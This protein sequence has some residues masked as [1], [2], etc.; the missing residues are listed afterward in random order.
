MKRTLILSV[1][2][3][4]VLGAA[5][6]ALAQSPS[7]GA[8]PSSTLR[9]GITYDLYTSNPLRACGCG[10]EY[11]WMALQYDML[12]NFDKNTLEPA[13]G[14]ATEVPS[15]DNG[16]ISEDGLTYTFTIR[17]DATWQDGEPVTSEDVAFTYRFMLDNKIGAYDNYL[18]YD[19]VFET[20]DE[21]TFIWTQSQ[22]SLAPIAPPFIPILPEHIWAE[23]D[24]DPKAARQFENIP[25]IGSGPFQLVEWKEGQFFRMEANAEYWGG[26][27]KV[28]EIVFRAYDN[29]E[30]MALALRDGELDLVS[31][32]PP[33]H[34]EIARRAAEHRRARGRGARVHELR[35]Q[36][37]GQGDS[38]TNHPALDDVTVRQAIAHAIDKQALVDKVLLG[39]GVVGAGLM[40]PSSPWHWA[41]EADQQ[42]AFDISSGRPDA[43]GRRIRGHR[44]RRR[45]R[46]A[47]RRRAARARGDRGVQRAFGAAVGPPHPGVARRD[48]YRRARE[49]RRG[50]RHEPG[51]DA[52]HVR[53][54]PLGVEPRPRPRLHPLDL[55]DRR[56]PG[57]ERRVLLRPRLRRDVRRAANGV[58][59]RGPPGR[60]GGHG[61][62]TSTRTCRSWSCT[63]SPTWRRSA[64]TPS[65][66]TP[67]IR[68]PNGYMVFGYL[69]SPYMDIRPVTAADGSAARYRIGHDPAVGVGCGRPSRSWAR[70]SWCRGVRRSREDERI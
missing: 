36:L 9:I 35:L 68:R 16:G 55:H 25:A 64:P 40:P 59:G 19:P 4:S 39:R 14:I 20:P 7:D 52:G 22:P 57:L 31:G 5:G 46:D 50:R 47:G 17:D 38:A 24:G 30:T 1:M 54:L 44:W 29:P 65:P 51:L 69:A 67:R 33:E 58:L 10:A 42:Y 28:D 49:G 62:A 70:S 37:R 41:P 18:P 45:P 27:P 48:R 26:A 43:R 23:Y 3:I 32:L 56:V 11:E 12:L 8:V 13:P 63:T 60:R 15:T 21:S 53:R 66:A 2:A 61:V 34:R 6:G